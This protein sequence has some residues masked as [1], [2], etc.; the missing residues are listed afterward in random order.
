[1]RTVSSLFALALSATA[2]VA[3]PVHA[4]LK[5]DSQIEVKAAVPGEGEY[6]V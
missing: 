2:F 1:M 5:P 4:L 3:R 6:I